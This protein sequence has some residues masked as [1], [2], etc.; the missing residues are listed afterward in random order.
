MRDSIQ[1]RIDSAG[2]C[3]AIL[4]GY[5]LCSNGV[6]GIM[7]R[8]C[9]V[10]LPRVDDCIALLLGSRERYLSEFEKEPGTYYLSPGWIDVGS[11]PL[12]VYMD[13]LTKYGGETALWVT[14]EMMKNYARVAY[15]E[16]R[17]PEGDPAVPVS[18]GGMTEQAGARQRETQP[19]GRDYR[20]Y[21]REVA[22]FLGLRYEE[23]QGSL[24]ALTQLFARGCSDP[25][26][27]DP[28]FVVLHP[29]EELTARSWGFMSD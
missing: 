14:T 16:T 24:E 20:R 1:E 25:R 6:L 10:I 15:V 23:I 22:T 12:K 28:G 11:D 4:L 26:A 27:G 13:A 29:G 21:A 9:P 17:L 3:G 2:E 19:A 5:G 18:V 7:A 8:T